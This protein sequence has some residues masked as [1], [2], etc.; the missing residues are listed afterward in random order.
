MYIR[1]GGVIRTSTRISRTWN[2]CDCVD[3]D[4]WNLGFCYETFTCVEN[5]TETFTVE[6]CKGDWGTV[7]MVDWLIILSDLAA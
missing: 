4:Y 1:D 6:G 2:C 3:L 5:E 7:G